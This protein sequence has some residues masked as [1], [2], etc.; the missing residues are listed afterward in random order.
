ML[1]GSSAAF[2]IDRQHLVHPREVERDAALD[3]EQVA[4]ERGADAVRNQRRAVSPAG[5]DHGD[6]LTRVFGTE[7]V[8]QGLQQG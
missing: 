1:C 4:F 7:G 5:R 3:G 8:A 6:H 2:W